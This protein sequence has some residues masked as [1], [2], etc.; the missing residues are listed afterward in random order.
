MVR[1]TKWAVGVGL[2]AGRRLL[3]SVLAAGCEFVGVVVGQVESIPG[4]DQ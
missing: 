2:A 1:P 4:D 3:K